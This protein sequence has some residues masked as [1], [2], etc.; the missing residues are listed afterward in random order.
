MEDMGD[1]R[2]KDAGVVRYRA[3]ECSSLPDGAPLPAP[4]YIYDLH[5]VRDGDLLVKELSVKTLLVVT[6]RWEAADGTHF[7]VSLDS[8]V[9]SAGYSTVRLIPA[10]AEE[11]VF[12]RDRLSAAKRLIYDANVGRNTLRPVAPPLATCQ[13]EP[14]E[15]LGPG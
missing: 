15:R 8:G 9:E 6:N 11:F 13:L 4:P 10:L 12:E 7:Y 3:A 14:F 1:L 2:V 5:Q